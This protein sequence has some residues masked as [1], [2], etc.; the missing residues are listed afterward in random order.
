MKE[1]FRNYWAAMALVVFAVALCAVEV[2]VPYFGLV[3][4]HFVA[5][6]VLTF[7]V[8]CFAFGINPSKSSSVVVYFITL[9]LVGGLHTWM[10]L[11]LTGYT[12]MVQILTPGVTLTLFS[13]V[14]TA[15]IVGHLEDRSFHKK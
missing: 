9:L 8:F 2:F 1:F 11:Y 14:P 5:S 12:E 3:F 4:Q 6:L 10:G 13:V 7:S 15:I